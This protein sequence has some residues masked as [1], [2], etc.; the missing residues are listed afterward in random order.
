[1]PMKFAK[2]HFIKKLILQDRSERLHAKNIN[3]PTL[4][5]WNI[6]FIFRVVIVTVYCM[7]NTD[8]K[9]NM[10]YRYIVKTI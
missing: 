10:V 5:L 4:H 8:N 6:V 1:M 3:F 7:K 9:T 2:K